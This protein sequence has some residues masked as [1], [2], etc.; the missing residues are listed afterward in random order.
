MS[1]GVLDELGYCVVEEKNNKKISM[2]KR[3]ELLCEMFI[4]TCAATNTN[5]ESSFS[6]CHQ[7]SGYTRL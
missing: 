6:T 5:L 1:A 4:V 3:C 7:P 2:Q